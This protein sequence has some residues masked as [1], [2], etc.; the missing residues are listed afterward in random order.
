MIQIPVVTTQNPDGTEI[1][2]P[3][4]SIP[5]NATWVVCDGENYTVYQPGDELPSLG[6]SEVAE[7]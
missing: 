2:S 7:D 4:S 6:A 1:H 5:S 3:E